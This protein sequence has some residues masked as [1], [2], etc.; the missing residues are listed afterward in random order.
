M[1]TVAPELGLPSGW[2]SVGSWGVMAIVIWLTFTRL[3]KT[4]AL[5]ASTNQEAITRLAKLSELAETLSKLTAALVREEERNGARLQHLIQREEE[6]SR[7]LHE[8]KE[9]AAE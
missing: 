2:E 4:M 7:T 5:V 9:T 6:N 8:I 1:G 3:D